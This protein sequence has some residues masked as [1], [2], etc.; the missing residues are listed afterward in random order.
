MSNKNPKAKRLAAAYRLRYAEALNVMREDSD[1]AE[2]MADEQ[3]ISF[4]EANRRIEG[5]YAQARQR[6]DEQGVSFRTALAWIRSGQAL[7]HQFA[8][9]AASFPTVEELLRRELVGAC[10]KL[11]DE[12]VHRDGDDN[13]EVH[14]LNFDGVHLPDYVDETEI[15]VA[16]P[17][18]DTLVWDETEELDGTTCLGTVRVHADVSFA[19]FMYRGDTYAHEGEITVL[20]ADWNERTSRVWFRRPVILEFEARV[21]LG[22]ESAELEFVS[23]I[24]DE[25]PVGPHSIAA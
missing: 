13:Y 19:G 4:A 16:T 15:D 7:Q 20:E 1:L 18:L 11:T 23:A 24:T 9:L 8:S 12:P 2:Q 14:G 17:D 3:N 6:A 21:E 25:Y 10:D 5:E 22:A